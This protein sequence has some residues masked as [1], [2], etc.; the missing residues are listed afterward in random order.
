M[1]RIT[2]GI[3]VTVAVV[4]AV[5]AILVAITCALGH[6]DYARVNR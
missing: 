2:K 6:E 1:N 3:A 4:M 5:W